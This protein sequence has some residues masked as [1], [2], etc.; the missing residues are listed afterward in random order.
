MFDPTR[1]AER[2]GRIPTLDPLCQLAPAV[3]GWGFS[4]HG[5]DKQI[6][7]VSEQS[8]GWGQSY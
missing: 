7:G 5:F 6:F 4:V 8:L 3:N 1:N 2:K